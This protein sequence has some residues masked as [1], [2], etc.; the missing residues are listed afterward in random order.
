MMMIIGTRYK[1]WKIRD[2]EDAWI[3]P[4]YRH[5]KV[6]SVKPRE[7][8]ESSLD[9]LEATSMTQKRNM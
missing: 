5:S 9:K 8:A 4:G 6:K 1:G 7:V 2:K 3:K